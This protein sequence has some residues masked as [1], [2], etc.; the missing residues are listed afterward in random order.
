MTYQI[1]DRATGELVDQNILIIPAGELNAT[2]SL[3]IADDDLDE[4]DQEFEVVITKTNADYTSD[5]AAV[6]VVY[7]NDVTPT[8]TVAS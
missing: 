1:I 6:F 3:P 2:V 7:D 8:A 5:G 4:Y